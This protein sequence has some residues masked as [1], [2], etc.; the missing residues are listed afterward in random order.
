MYLGGDHRYRLL[1]MLSTLVV[2][3]FLNVLFLESNGLKFA[4][5]T[6]SLG[7]LILFITYAIS[8]MNADQ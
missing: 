8:A 5:F 7:H 4:A 6:I 3:F 2:I 1:A